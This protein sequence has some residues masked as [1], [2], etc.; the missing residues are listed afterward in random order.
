MGI[1]HNTKGTG[2]ITGNPLQCAGRW[3]K[4]RLETCFY[5][6]Q[7]HR[8]I[9]TWYILAQCIELRRQKELSLLPYAETKSNV[10]G[11]RL[12]VKVITR[13]RGIPW[14]H[15]S[16]KSVLP[17]YKLTYK[18]NHSFISSTKSYISFLLYFFILLHCTICVH[19][20]SV[21]RKYM[22]HIT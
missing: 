17:L 20:P 18:Q 2:W 15:H 4:P 13:H 21:P 10:W 5:L 19:K 9:Q 8:L 3:R 7:A 11:Y 12:F 16:I 14:C 1:R 6:F 22:R